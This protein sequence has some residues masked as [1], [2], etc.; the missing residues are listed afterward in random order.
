MNKKGK[1]IIALRKKGKTYGEIA[2]MLNLPKSTVAWWLRDVKISKSLQKQIL[3]KSR[4]KWRKNITAYNKVYAK[5]RSREATRI[6][7]KYKEKAAKEI[8]NLSKKDLKLIGSALYWAEGNT[9]NRHC[10]RFSNSDPLMIKAMIRFLR[11]VCKIPDEKIKARIH[12][13]PGINQQKTTN[14]WKKI[15]R[16]PKRNFH[17][18]Q[19]QVSRASKG[20]R[21]RNTL[22]YGT[23]HL[24]AG[25]TEITCKVK[26][27]IEGIINLMRE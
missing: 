18:P 27:W 15:T 4:E 1:R 8:K 7:E 3:E 13:Y 10:I 12:L 19:I 6:R 5:I 21:P 25:N 26:G 20:K 9:K 16:L 23:L 11:E 24:R 14:Y 17:P 22:P 2:E